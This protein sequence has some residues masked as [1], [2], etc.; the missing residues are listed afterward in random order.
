[1]KRKSLTK[2]AALFL[3]GAMLLS[4]CGNSVAENQ[5]VSST[6]NS[7]TVETST[8]ATADAS[9]AELDKS[10]YMDT[11]KPI[12][13][14][15]AA[16]LSQMT[17]EEKVGQ[18]VQ[19]EQ[20]SITPD[21]VTEYAVGSVLSGGGSC[22]STGNNAINWQD[23]VNELKSAALNT[24][25][26]IP[27]IYGVDAVHGNNNVFGAT[28]FPH[29]IGL[30]AANDPE[31]MEE[32]GAVVASEV[33]AIAVQWTFCPTLGD[34]QNIRWG[35]SYECFSERTSDIAPLA[36][37]YIQGIQGSI[38]DGEYMDPKRVIAC[39][40]HF[41]GEG[42]TKDGIN[43]GNV[44]MTSEEFDE[45]LASGVITPYTSAIDAG[46]LTVMASYNSVNGVKCHENKHLLTEVLKDQL[47]FTG[48]VVSDYNA[49]EQTSGA[50]YKDQVELCVNAGIDM[51]MEPTSWKDCIDALLQLV[52]EGRVTQERI[53]DAV[54]RILRVK[55]IS[56]MFEEVIG[57]EI[58]ASCLEEF[59]SEA[60][61]EV[62][63]RAV[64]E[65]LVLLKNEKIGDQTA[66][67]K[68]TSAT[69]IT[70]AGSKAYDIGSQCGG[71]T[72]SWQGQS[73]KI[74]QGTTIIEAIAA[75]RN[76]GVS[77]AHSK[78]GSLADGTDAVVAVFGEVPYAETSGDRTGD[79]LKVSADDEKMLAGL[80][81]N[82]SALPDDVPVIGIVMAG[83]P[84]NITEYEDMF[85]VIIMSWLPGTEG[86]G[87]TDI[88]M[89]E[90]DFTGTLKYTWMKD[91][92]DIDKKDS[93][94][95][96]LILYPYGTGLNKAGEQ[97]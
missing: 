22:P 69:S 12:E 95:E 54:S 34:P 1:M 43:Q 59:G 52:E 6:E 72:I 14:R 53:D 11:S 45:L 87:V 85:D 20:M 28:V 97:L 39:A 4:A 31:L 32:I 29:N 16:L 49:I 44:D 13:E 62:A 58:D 3:T 91:M 26:G 41:I 57:G 55:F 10:A 25:L 19:A 89:G 33:R 56:G 74:T 23:R 48:F 46:V 84:I 90:Y 42:Y 15:V 88:L 21:E 66:F 18:M 51:F 63:R 71:W 7:A 36:Y 65:S 83:R 9:P 60:H 94:D 24:R 78:D 2:L 68:L 5:P 81:E 40:K 38:A 77:L 8:E 80:R 79:T 17:L 86:E 92:N 67:E 35:R 27:L 47:G 82:I 61:R 37:S 50:T 93:G 75:A 96:S 73:G 70:V 30:G 64:R 76:E